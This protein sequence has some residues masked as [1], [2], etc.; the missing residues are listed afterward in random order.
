M[1]RFVTDHY[2][3]VVGFYY[4]QKVM[5]LF[6]D[7]T[8]HYFLSILILSHFIYYA[9]LSMDSSTSLGVILTVKMLGYLTKEGTYTLPKRHQ[10]QQP[11][12]QDRLEQQS[13]VFPNIS[14]N[15]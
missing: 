9:A 12:N 4:D 1:H 13:Q 3:Q 14:S 11:S 5:C 6:F 2:L 15:F 7:R 8:R 10:F